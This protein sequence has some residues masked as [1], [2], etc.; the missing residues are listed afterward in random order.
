[1]SNRDLAVAILIQHPSID[2]PVQN[3]LFRNNAMESYSFFIVAIQLWKIFTP[4]R[5][6]LCWPKG[7]SNDS[8]S[9]RQDQIIDDR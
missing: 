8:V 5:T 1:M 9:V 7:A 3:I 4:W 2:V 6:P